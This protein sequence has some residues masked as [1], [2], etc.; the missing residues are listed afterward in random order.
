[1]SGCKL[2]KNRFKTTAQATKPADHIFTTILAPSES[3]ASHVL[4]LVATGAEPSLLGGG[5]GGCAQR[6]NFTKEVSYYCR[7]P[8]R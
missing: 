1:M 5:L 2:V 8:P 4:Y 7:N 3:V 6:E